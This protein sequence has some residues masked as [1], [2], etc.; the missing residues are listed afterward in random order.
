MNWIQQDINGV[1]FGRRESSKINDLGIGTNCKRQRI[2]PYILINSFAKIISY[3]LTKKRKQPTFHAIE[4]NQKESL[5]YPITNNQETK[6]IKVKIGKANSGN[7]Y[8]YDRFDCVHDCWHVRDCYHHNGE[9]SDGDWDWNWNSHSN[10]NWK[11]FGIAIV[12]VMKV[13]YLKQKQNL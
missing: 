4:L 6:D 10:S 13:F 2:T 7:A 1:Y 12:T 8:S 5:E 3:K 11:F 9:D